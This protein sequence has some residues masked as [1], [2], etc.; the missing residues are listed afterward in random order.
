MTIPEEQRIA[1]LGT[2]VPQY[3][4]HTEDE[5]SLVDLF[6]VL[7]RHKRLIGA[8]FLLVT[9]LAALYAV[10]R[11]PS[12]VYTSSVQIGR[13]MTGLIETPAVVAAKLNESYIPYVRHEAAER[14]ELAPRIRAE[15]PKDGDIVVLR[16]TGSLDAAEMHDALHRLVVER[17]ARDQEAALNVARRN[18]QAEAGRLN[19]RFQRL[20]AERELLGE[21]FERLGEQEGVLQ[22]NLDELRKA[23]TETQ[24]SRERLVA[25][26]DSQAGAALLFAD[27]ELARMRERE[28]QLGEDLMSGIALRRDGIRSAEIEN[29]SLQTEVQ[30][31][32]GEL[33]T[34]QQMLR[35]TAAM[36]PTIRLAE[37][38]GPGPGVIVAAGLV[39]GLA[40]GVFLAF[41]AEFA[42]RTRERLKEAES[43]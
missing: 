40:A 24:A 22:R 37:P 10:L 7:E 35:P 34:R 13:S 5:L 27:G 43:L 4:S 6:L 32:L 31:K 1:P 21:R 8:V 12:Y 20:Q 38:T 41:I 19:G 42:A 3:V 11:T 26:G 28:Q 23:I 15:A 9:L 29:L 39:L 18:L 16:S 2:R 14:G 36:T 33:E 30:E 25:R 17:L